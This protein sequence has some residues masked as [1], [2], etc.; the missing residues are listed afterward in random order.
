MVCDIRNLNNDKLIPFRFSEL[1][2]W[3]QQLVIRRPV[4]PLSISRW[5]AA[6]P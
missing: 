3:T 1:P 4:L 5:E 2:L 6:C